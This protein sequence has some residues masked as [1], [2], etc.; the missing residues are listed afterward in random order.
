[1]SPDTE[2][3]EQVK[4]VAFPAAIR[5]AAGL[6]KVNPLLQGDNHAFGTIG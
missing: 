6:N 3:D 4:H 5:A 1:M 2:M